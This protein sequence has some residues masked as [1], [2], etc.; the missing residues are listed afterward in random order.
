MPL[1]LPALHVS[2][3]ARAE[4]SGE[5]F[6]ASRA[7]TRASGVFVV[8]LSVHFDPAVDAWPTGSVKI[9]TD[10]TDGLN[11]TFR[12]TS[13]ETMNAYGRH[14]P[15]IVVGG[16]C[17]A[18]DGVQAVGLRFWLTAVD[19][20]QQMDHGTPDV[21]GFAIHD[22]HGSRVA[23]GMGPLRRGGIRVTPK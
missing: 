14:S 16:R 2:D 10:L 1:V 6:I 7:D 11:G 22:R 23:Y 15:T 5:V 13:I 20:R 17:L 12:A 3:F 8:T 9:K 21:V 18:G 19:N 4:G